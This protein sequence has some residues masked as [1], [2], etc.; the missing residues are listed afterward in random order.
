MM[1]ETAGQRSVRMVVSGRVQGV[2]F[3]Y[4]TRREATGLGLAGWVK[5]L[6]SGQ[7]ELRVR[8]AEPALDAL[9]R[10]LRRGPRGSRVTGLEEW[11][12]EADD[13]WSSFRI[14]Y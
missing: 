9:R 2:G 11:P 3:R 1:G 14:E 8:G 4:F 13:D 10:R 7:V 6:P 12:I 5:N